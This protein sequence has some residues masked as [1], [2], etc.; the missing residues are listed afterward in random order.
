MTNYTQ[1]GVPCIRIIIPDFTASLYYPSDRGTDL[2]RTINAI[3]AFRNKVVRGEVLTRETLIY[4][5]DILEYPAYTYE[6]SMTKL[7][8]ILTEKISDAPYLYSPTLFTAYL[9][10]YL[11]E[12]EIA[13]K[14]IEQ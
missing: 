1:Y 12:Y 2:Y 11:K 6:F 14:Y 10:L 3:K 5:Q 4:I 9:E 13:V 7:L 8:G